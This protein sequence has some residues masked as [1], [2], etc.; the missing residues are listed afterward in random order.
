MCAFLEVREH[1]SLSHKTGDKLIVLHILIFTVFG[2]RWQD[3]LIIN[4]EMM[5]K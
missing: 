1:V 4:G 2:S 5:E 3:K